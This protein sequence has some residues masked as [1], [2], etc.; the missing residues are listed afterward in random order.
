MSTN[1]ELRGRWNELTLTKLG[2]ANISCCVEIFMGKILKS[3]GGGQPSFWGK[4]KEKQIH[5]LLEAVRV[6]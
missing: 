3:L 5:T 4:K 2:H 6:V 1:K